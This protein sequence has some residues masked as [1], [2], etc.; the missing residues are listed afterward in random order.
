MKTLILLGCVIVL[1]GCSTGITPMGKD[2]YFVSYK[3]SAFATAGSAKAKC[4]RLADDFCAK[5]G[6]AMVPKSVLAHETAPFAPATCELEFLAV[7]KD[8]PR[9]QTPNLIRAPDSVNVIKQ[10]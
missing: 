9:N 3:G 10:Q 5:R 7:P 4:Y 8:D 2:T 6:L 1:A